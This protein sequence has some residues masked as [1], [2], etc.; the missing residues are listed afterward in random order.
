MREQWQIHKQ[1]G[2]AWISHGMTTTMTVIKT[3]QSP[4]TTT[5]LHY[6]PLVRLARWHLLLEKRCNSLLL[7]AYSSQ[8]GNWKLSSLQDFEELPL[9][10]QHWNNHQ[11][12][13]SGVCYSSPYEQSS[14][15]Q[16]VLPTSEF[17]PAT[18]ELYAPT[19]SSIKYDFLRY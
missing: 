18:N 12:L 1:Q 5:P 13:A 9:C 17:P 7:Q 11:A 8:Q 16:S 10:W 15:T 3:C 4:V 6:W 14:W 19:N 2:G